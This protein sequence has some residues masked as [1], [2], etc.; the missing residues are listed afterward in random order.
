VAE[1]VH[2]WGASAGVADAG[3]RW[4]HAPLQDFLASLQGGEEAQEWEAAF[5][6]VLAQK[7]EEPRCAERA[8]LLVAEMEAAGRPWF[9]KEPSLGFFLPFWERFWRDP[10]YLVVVRNPQDAAKSFEKETL[11][12]PLAARIRLTACQLLLWQRFV[13]AVL[14]RAG[15]A[16]S[17]IFVSYED[18]LR[19]PMEHGRR[20]C[21]FLDAQ[22]GRGAG[23]MQRL[24]DMLEAIDPGSWHQKSGDLSQAS[25]AQV[26]LLDL[27]RARARDRDE[28][29]AAESYPMPVFAPEYLRNIDL[30]LEHSKEYGET[31]LGVAARSRR[32]SAGLNGDTARAAAAPRGGR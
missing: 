18:L 5:A 19:S 27:L 3:S 4:V 25:P 30:L 6:R 26:A 28:P 9:W 10:I 22:C 31:L 12:P 16:S 15:A 8:G 7:A 24:G 1:L 20:L 23:D 11:P 32:R 2:R 29:F 14:D 13:L 21:R 17:S